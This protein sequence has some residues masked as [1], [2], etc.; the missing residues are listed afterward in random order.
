MANGDLIGARD[1]ELTMPSGKR[2][3]P[4]V[5][6]REAGYETWD[7]RTVYTLTA[8]EPQT[9]TWEHYVYSKVDTLYD[10][11]D[12]FDLFLGKKPINHGQLICSAFGTDSLQITGIFP[13]VL[14]HPSL[15]ITPDTFGFG[16]SVLGARA[17]EMPV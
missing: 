16:L 3:K 14:S 1:D 5:Q 13:P 2:V 8:L 7:R 12:I 11:R 15:Q 17:E 4:G 6:I 9:S 10:E